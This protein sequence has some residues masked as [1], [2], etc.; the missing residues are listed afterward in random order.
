MSAGLT[1]NAAQADY[2]LWGT[3]NY[4]LFPELRDQDDYG[5]GYY[6]RRMIYGM[7]VSK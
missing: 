7:Y 2:E 6:E 5:A 4:E 1:D 3:M